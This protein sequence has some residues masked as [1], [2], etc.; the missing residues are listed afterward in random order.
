MTESSRPTAQDSAETPDR[1]LI[2]TDQVELAGQIGLALSH[3]AFTIQIAA[4]AAEASTLR[5]DWRPNLVLVEMEMDGARLMA[6]FASGSAD[7]GHVPVIA[8]TRRGDL[9]TKLLAWGCGV[10]DI[11]SVP[12]SPDELLARAVTVMRRTHR[13]DFELLSPA[14]KVGEL[15]IDVLRRVVRVGTFEVHLTS[16]EEALL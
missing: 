7:R 9:E 16:L 10:D 15:E 14:I 12:F 5:R 3:G 8:L 4:S 1:A 11:L 13:V 6:E 2:V